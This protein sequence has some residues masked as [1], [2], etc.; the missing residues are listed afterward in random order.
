MKFTSYRRRFIRFHTIVWKGKQNL[1]SETICPALNGLQGPHN[2]SITTPFIV[3]G[4]FSYWTCFLHTFPS[5][6]SL[7]SNI[8]WALGIT[9]HTL[10]TILQCWHFIISRLYV[11]HL[12]SFFTEELLLSCV[13]LFDPTGC[14]MPGTPVHYRLEFAQIHVHWVGDAI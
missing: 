1:L 11:L 2:Q 12:F 4:H 7:P 14:S 13:Q 5:A 10:H 8:L 9:N 3:S 6:P